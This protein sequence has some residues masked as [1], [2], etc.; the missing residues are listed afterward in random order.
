MSSD[1]PPRY[2][3]LD[4]QNP[5]RM[6]LY[7]LED[8]SLDDSWVYGAPFTTPPETPITVG[9]IPGYEQAEL[10]PYFGTPPVMSEKFYAALVGAGVDNLVAYEAVLASED[11]KVRHQ[12]FKA[13]NLIGLVKAADLRNTA[14]SADNESRLIDA[15]IES[16]AIDTEKARGLLMFRLAEYSGAVIVHD[17]VKQ[18][19]ET[20]NFPHVVF[21]E[22]KDFIS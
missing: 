11:G 16:L 3:V 1:N 6:L 17:S 4:A 8:P 14:F 12:G 21:R 10:M 5:K 15:G 22:P 7:S 18:A 2:Y 13:F 20:L 9:I 19:I